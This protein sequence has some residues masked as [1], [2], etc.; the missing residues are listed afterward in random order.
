MSDIN[1]ISIREHSEY[2]DKAVDY[3]SSKWGIPH[4]IYQDCIGHSMS[5]NSPLPRWYVMLRGDRII[6]S[7]G[8]ITN[9]FVSRQD[10]WPWLAALYIEKEERGSGLGACLLEHGRKEAHKLGFPT[11]YL[12]TDHMGYYEKYDWKFIATAYDVGGE[13]T[14]IYEASSLIH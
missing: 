4:N 2:L 10:L 5:T 11:V 12:S 7:Y 3:F 8:L 9:D 6:G 14:R 1:I 13:S